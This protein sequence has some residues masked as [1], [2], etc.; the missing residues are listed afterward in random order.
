MVFR[1]GPRSSISLTQRLT[2]RPERACLLGEN[3]PEQRCFL[4]LCAPRFFP[5][6]QPSPAV[7]EG[8]RSLSLPLAQVTGEDHTFSLSFTPQS[9]CQVTSQER[10]CA[11]SMATAI[12]QNKYNFQRLGIEAHTF[13]HTK[14]GE[15]CEFKARLV[16]D[17]VNGTTQADWVSK[18]QHHH[19]QS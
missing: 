11:V 19:Q 18:Q 16:L 2:H 17:Q 15:L 7:P 5:R 6:P 14:E 3:T 13:D 12:Q 1:V 8:Q 10:L 4:T 9:L